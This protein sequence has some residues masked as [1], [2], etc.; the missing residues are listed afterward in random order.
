MERYTNRLTLIIFLLINSLAWLCYLYITAYNKIFVTFWILITLSSTI[1]LWNVGKRYDRIKFHAEKDFLTNIYNRRFVYNNFP[2]LLKKVDEKKEKIN[3]FVLDIDNFKKIN[4]T[5]GH[6][7]G[8][9][10]LKI[11]SDSLINTKEA[12]EIIA[13]WG[14][15]EFILLIPSKKVIKSDQITKRIS[16]NYSSVTDELCIDISIGSAVYPDQGNN[17]EELIK[18]ADKNMYRH[19]FSKKNIKSL[20]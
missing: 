8:D 17:L 5:K 18:T 11:I 10:I 4:D 15:D 3:L 2:R 16:R 20:E 1:T 9:L 14:G 12:G 13:R 7:Y 6:D 19:K